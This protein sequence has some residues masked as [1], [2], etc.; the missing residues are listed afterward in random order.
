[1]KG[2]KKGLG[3]DL[4]SKVEQAIREIRQ[5]PQLGISYKQTDFRYWIVRR[6]PYVIFYME[7]E[8]SIWIAAIAHGR[9]RPDY[10]RKRRIE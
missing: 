9:R 5:N 1:M 4:Q 7:L 3:Q 8:E 6:F 10:W 2:K